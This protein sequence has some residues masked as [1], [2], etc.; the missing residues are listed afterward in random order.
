MTAQVLNRGH[1]RIRDRM[2]LRPGPG[3][4]SSALLR[5]GC[6]VFKAGVGLG[7]CLKLGLGL[8]RLKV[9][10]FLCGTACLT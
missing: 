10:G 1:F 5:E 4:G 8:G 6:F 3:P 7:L 2:L 9:E